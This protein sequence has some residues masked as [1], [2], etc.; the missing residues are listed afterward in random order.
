[1]AQPLP[2]LDRN[3][4]WFE[5]HAWG[6][7]AASQ[8]D[9]VQNTAPGALSLDFL[10]GAAPELFLGCSSSDPKRSHWRFTAGFSPPGAVINDIPGAEAAYESGT[11]RLLGAAGNLV[12]RDAAGRELARLPMRPA[13]GQPL[14]ETG[15]LD[16]ASLA[17]F[18]AAATILVETP[19]I[20]IEAGAREV[21]G[22]LSRLARLPCRAG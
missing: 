5:S 4:G 2:V 7:G 11:R 16:A 15:P 20:R 13:A 9:L 8:L 6:G 1:M 12:L 17:R 10:G 22:V 3:N 19:R 14:L 21:D 18:R